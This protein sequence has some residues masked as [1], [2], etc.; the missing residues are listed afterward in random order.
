MNKLRADDIRKKPIYI[1]VQI[2]L[3]PVS[4]SE[5]ISYNIHVEGRR[6]APTLNTPKE[7]PKITEVLL[8]N[9]SS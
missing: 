6:R 5:Y 8:Q 9:G 2:F 4:C 1:Q 7:A 3:F